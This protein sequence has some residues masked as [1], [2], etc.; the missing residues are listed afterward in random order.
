M[1][2]AAC[3]GLGLSA[4][5]PARDI[6]QTKNRSRHTVYRDIIYHSDAKTLYGP[7]DFKVTSYSAEKCLAYNVPALES[8]EAEHVEIADGLEVDL[9]KTLLV[10]YMV[11]VADVSSRQYFAILV[12]TKALTSLQSAPG[13]GRGAAS[14]IGEDVVNPKAKAF[15]DCLPELSF[16]GQAL[17][18]GLPIGAIRSTVF[19][20][21]IKKDVHLQK[22]AAVHL[23]RALLATGVN[24]EDRSWVDGQGRVATPNRASESMR[25]QCD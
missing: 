14:G 21:V 11:A 1:A 2:Q 13:P 7:M 5:P 10:K 3:R 19:L 24:A 22:K 4:H 25:R 18:S 8:P 17:F 6:P 15:G 12:Q 20:R 16:H 9:L 23:E